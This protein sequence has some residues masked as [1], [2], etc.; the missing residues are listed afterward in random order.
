MNGNKWLGGTLA[1]RMQGA[2]D[3][4]FAGANGSDDGDGNVG[5]RNA[6]YQRAQFLHGDADTE[7]AHGVVTAFPA[8]A[9][10]SQLKLETPL[11]QRALDHDTQE[12]RID[13]LGEEVPGTALYGSQ[14]E[15]A[16]GVPGH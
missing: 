6:P 12:L 5:W 4:F 9:Q 8:L 2:R 14:R 16:F 10:C 1:V 15:L 11:G 7:Q 3:Q 13:G